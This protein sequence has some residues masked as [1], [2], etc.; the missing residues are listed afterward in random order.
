MS[1]PVRLRRFRGAVQ[2]HVEREMTMRH[3]SAIAAALRKAGGMA[4]MAKAGL[5]NAA[6]DC[7]RRARMSHFH[8][9]DA[10]L[11]RIEKEP[12]LLLEL[13]PRHDIRA[14]A[15]IY[16]SARAKDANNESAAGASGGGAE[17]EAQGVAR[18]SAPKATV[19]SSSAPPSAARR[20][21]GGEAGGEAHRCVRAPAHIDKAASPPAAPK[22]GP[23]EFAA[24]RAAA[25]RGYFERAFRL[26]QRPLGQ[27]RYCEL[28]RF[29]K[30]GETEALL[31]RRLIDL[32]PPADPN[33][34]LMDYL[35]ETLVAKIFEEI[36]L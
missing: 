31:A 24:M 25:S 34:R 13:I 23:A 14:A 20:A 33:A 15:S 2:Q 7:L 9:L 17:E 11:A 35:D 18:A 1:A 32:G 19:A 10:F 30:I 26:A 36:G 12:E 28:A 16:L 5:F 29:A 3:E 27:V 8:A 4:V 6:I 21:P 22:R